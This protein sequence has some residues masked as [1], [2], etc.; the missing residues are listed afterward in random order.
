MAL[1]KYPRTKAQPAFQKNPTAVLAASPNRVQNSI[2]NRI[3]APLLIRNMVG[4]G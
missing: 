4:F 2:E 3:S 1:I